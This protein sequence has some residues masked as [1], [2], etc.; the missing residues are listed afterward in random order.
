[1]TQRVTNARRPAF[2]LA[3]MLITI[4]LTSMLI[5]TIY[6]LWSFARRKSASLEARVETLSTGQ[7]KLHGMTR[8]LMR[9]R[10]LIYPA[11]GASAQPGVGVVNGE[12]DVVMYH[13]QGGTAAGASKQLVRTDVATG[14]STVVLDG[15]HE[16][17]CRVAAVPSGRAPHLVHVTLSLEAA[18]SAPVHLITSARLRAADVVCTINR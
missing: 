15:V 9:A 6:Q 10:R 16:L 12:G 17:S 7:R 4:A 8:E 5:T 14:S 18:G 3:E 2:T 11:S 13:V 1:M